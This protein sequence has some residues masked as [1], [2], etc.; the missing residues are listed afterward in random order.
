[1]SLE[2]IIYKSL[3]IITWQLEVYLLFQISIY[4]RV[5]FAH[6]IVLIIS[7]RLVVERTL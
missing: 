5:F 3:K 2:N 1:M 6:D 4:S 7:N